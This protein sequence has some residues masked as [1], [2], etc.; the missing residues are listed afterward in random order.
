M[1]FT[2]ITSIIK[3]KERSIVVVLATILGFLVLIFV[4]GEIISPH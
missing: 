1:F 2:G 4:S 3:E